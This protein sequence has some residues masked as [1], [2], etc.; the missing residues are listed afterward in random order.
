MI[1]QIKQMLGGKVASELAERFGLSPEMVDMV[2]DKVTEVVAAKLGMDSGSQGGGGLSGLLS[3]GLNL[4]KGGGGDMIQQLT[5]AL[6]SELPQ[7]LQQTG[8]FDGD[9][10][11]NITKS[12]T[13]KV[14]EVAQ[15]FLGGN[16]GGGLM[17]KLGDLF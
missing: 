17:D 2:V 11:Q 1:E 3:G 16:D 5:G 6:G 12:I 7:K 14:S 9:L 15:Q 4:L 10:A 13:P 8:K